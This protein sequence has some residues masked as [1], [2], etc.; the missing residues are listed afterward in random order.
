MPSFISQ[1]EKDIANLIDDRDTSFKVY[2]KEDG[3]SY[4]DFTTELSV[5]EITD[6]MDMTRFPITFLVKNKMPKVS[7]RRSEHR[8]KAVVRW[9]MIEMPGCCGI[10][11]MSDLFVY[12][13]FRQKGV[14]ER[15]ILFAQK[16]AHRLNYKVMLGTY[17]RSDLGSQKALTSAK[18]RELLSFRN[19]NTGNKVNIS[20]AVL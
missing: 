12:P 16:V 14:G 3:Y 17:L 6:N 4:G 9:N 2:I 1:Y 13:G 8:N 19:R 7:S 10:V 20:A 5:S 18:W 15:T 11:I